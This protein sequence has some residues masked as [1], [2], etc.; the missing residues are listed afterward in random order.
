MTATTGND[1][2][3]LLRQ[4]GEVV[5]DFVKKTSND[6]GKLRCHENL[7]YRVV[8]LVTFPYHAIE[9]VVKALFGAFLTTAALLFAC[10][11][12]TLNQLAVG[13]FRKS[14][15]SW[16]KMFFDFCGVFAPN[17]A[18]EKVVSTNSRNLWTIGSLFV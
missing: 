9:M 11:A 5:S 3:S 10:Q 7:A 1:T 6:A 15:L 8:C 12:H 17:W 4:Q 18:K 16:H 14:N 13:M 2:T